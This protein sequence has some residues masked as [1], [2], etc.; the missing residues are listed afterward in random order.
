MPLLLLAKTSS[1]DGNVVHAASGERLA[2]SDAVSLI[3]VAG[4]ILGAAAAS[5][6]FPP[7]NAVTMYLVPGKGAWQWVPW[8]AK[9]YESWAQERGLKTAVSLAMFIEP[10]DRPEGRKKDLNAT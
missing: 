3:V 7:R 1:F 9:S 10:K 2:I 5:L 4:L 6:L 8:M